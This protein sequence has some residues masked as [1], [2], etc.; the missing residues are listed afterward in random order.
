MNCIEKGN[1]TDV[2]EARYEIFRVTFKMDI[3]P[4]NQN[5]LLLHTKRSNYQAGIHRRC[6][7]TV[8]NA[9]SPQEHGWQLTTNAIDIIWNTLNTAPDSILKAV[10][11]SCK[12]SGCTH[13]KCACHA[14]NLKC[15]AL[16]RCINCE[17]IPDSSEIESIIT[18][19]IDSDSEDEDDNA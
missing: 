2:N 16:S 12:K 6:L 5:A 8:I 13:V 3:L 14:N 9:P 1:V 17:N 19:D 10:Y 7:Q 11:C 18:C 15:S 4:P